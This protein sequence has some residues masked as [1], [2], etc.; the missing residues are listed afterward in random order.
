MTAESAASGED[1]IVY[2]SGEFFAD[3]MVLP[4][5]MAASDVEIALRNIGIYLR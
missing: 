3:E 5:G 4:A 1:A 2:L